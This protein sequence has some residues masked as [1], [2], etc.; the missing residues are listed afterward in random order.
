MRYS[1]IFEK[2][3]RNMP[4]DQ[5]AYLSHH[6]Q[7]QELYPYTYDSAADV[8]SE[9]SYSYS[10]NPNLYRLPLIFD[11]PFP[12]LKSQHLLLSTFLLELEVFGSLYKALA[13]NVYSHRN[14]TKLHRKSMRQTTAKCLLAIS[15]KFLAILSLIMIYYVPVF[16]ANHSAYQAR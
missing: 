13:E 12:P 9:S 3:L 7:S 14:S 2:T 10:F 11:V 15:Q 6:L 4:L 16:H 1:E 8:A 5:R